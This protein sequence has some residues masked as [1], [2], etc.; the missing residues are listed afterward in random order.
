MKKGEVCVLQYGSGTVVDPTFHNYAHNFQ[1]NN[2]V[3]LVFDQ[4][5][6]KEGAREYVNFSRNISGL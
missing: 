6:V 5:K 4:V 3:F 1:F 2:S